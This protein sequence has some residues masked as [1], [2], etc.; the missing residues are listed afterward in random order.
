MR[1]YQVQE[2]PICMCER[3]RDDANSNIY[4]FSNTLNL[5]SIDKRLKYLEIQKEFGC[6][7]MD[8]LGSDMH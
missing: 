4:F 6:H 2:H 8:Y 5:M 1:E 7:T 3:E